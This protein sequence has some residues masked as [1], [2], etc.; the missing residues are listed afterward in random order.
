MN[1]VLEA[2]GASDGSRAWSLT[3]GIAAAA[4]FVLGAFINARWP[5]HPGA[6]PPPEALMADFALIAAYS[7]FL[8]AAASAGLRERPATRVLAAGAIISTLIAAAADVTE[9]V[10]GLRYANGFNLE[11][12]TIA[13]AFKW[14]YFFG[15]VLFA[16]GVTALRGARVRQLGGTILIFAGG[17]GIAGSVV[18]NLPL[19]DAAVVLATLGAIVGYVLPLV[20][21][22]A[23]RAPLASATTWDDQRQAEARS[24]DRARGRAATASDDPA[25]SDRFGLALSGGGI[26]S[27]TFNLGLL[28]ALDAL[29][30]L[31]LFDYF[32][33][34]SGGGYIGAFW[35]RWRSRNP[36]AQ[37]PF[38]RPAADDVE[39]KE[40][41]HLR[42]FSNFLSPRLGVLSYD[43]GRMVVAAVSATIPALAAALSLI[44]LALE[45]W[46]LLAWLILGPTSKAGIPNELSIVVVGL[47]AGIVLVIVEE[48]WIK[49]ERDDGA[50]PVY[51]AAA[52]IA[53]IL[54]GAAW[55]GFQRIHSLPSLYAKV[56]F[57]LPVIRD[58]QASSDWLT[59]FLP[60][61][62]WLTAALI[63][64]VGRWTIWSASRDATARAIRAAFDRVTSRL[65]FMATGWVVIATLWILG[66][67]LWHWLFAG[68]GNAT[69]GIAGLAGT[70]AAL[71]VAFRSVQRLFTRQPNKPAGGQLAATLRPK[72]PQL[73]AYATIALL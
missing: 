55:W 42:E 65:L 73:I 12:A 56:W 48:V 31:H 38:P 18:G 29:E 64:V 61:G 60:A 70:T 32:A 21:N 23:P 66:A 33:T 28:Q 54:S 69:K 57:V 30:V 59:L 10:Y 58:E 26:R 14:G 8:I 16:G 50:I 3:A 24:I 34:V 53:M 37:E 15:A 35:S 49:R 4:M 51:A 9:N 11:P 71:G 27:A 13:T 44:L 72:L 40:V 68:S 20:T 41:R 19:R 7:T 63:L 6:T 43:T 17:V 25:S 2:R 46:V 62:A 5:S 1:D 47:V 45:A 39:A 67:V 52:A 36:A 22:R